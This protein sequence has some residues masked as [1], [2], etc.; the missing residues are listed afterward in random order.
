M[1]KFQRNYTLSVEDRGGQIITITLPLGIR[2]DVTRN[3]LSS[4]NSCKISIF[5]LSRNIREDLRKNQWETWDVRDMTLRAGYGDNMPI[6]FTGMLMQGSSVREGA[7]YVTNLVGYD[8]GA[9]FANGDVSVP[10]DGGST[11]KDVV[12]GLV[13]ALPGVTLGHIGD[14]YNSMPNLTR[15]NSFSGNGTDI[16]DQVTGGGFFIDNGQAHVLGDGDY[17][18]DPPIVI[19]SASGLLGV[20]VLEDTFLNFDILFDPRINV[21]QLIQLDSY[22]DRSF[23][24]HYIVRSVSHKAIISDSVTGEAVTSIGVFAN[25][26]LT[27]GP[28]L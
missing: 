8:G 10:L 17:L 16:L 1:D 6:I 5:N 27:I 11:F 23:N 26:A 15:G 4:A 21:G 28:D 7:T 22:A 25:E 24:G 12:Q 14:S 19:N 2:F 18:P 20:P 13:T 3:T 9:A